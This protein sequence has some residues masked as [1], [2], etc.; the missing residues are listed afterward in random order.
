MSNIG[1]NSL[2]NLFANQMQ[3]KTSVKTTENFDETL[4]DVSENTK[5]PQIEAKTTEKTDVDKSNDEKET[6]VDKFET[7]KKR[8]IVKKQEEPTE[9]QMVAAMEEVVSQIKE[10]I[11]EQ[12]GITEEELD[13]LM[14]DLGISDNQILDVN[15]LSQIV[16]KLDG[17]EKPLDMLMSPKFNDDLKE[18]LN[19]VEQIKSESFD[20]EKLVANVPENKD[21]AFEEDVEQFGNVAEMDVMV[22]A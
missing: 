2:D 14:T 1:V 3:A 20:L 9:E 17:I 13:N 7:S 15:V 19:K 21:V 6:T 16:M 12:F 11:Q 4:R 5:K 10:F 18:L 22:E 8:E